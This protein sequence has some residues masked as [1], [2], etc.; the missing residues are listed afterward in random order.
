MHEELALVLVGR[1]VVQD[2]GGQAVLAVV[3]VPGIK[4]LMLAIG[5]GPALCI[6]GVEHLRPIDHLVDHGIIDPALLRQLHAEQARHADRVDHSVSG[7]DGAVVVRCVVAPRPEGVRHR[8]V[9]AGS[10]RNVDGQGFD[11]RKHLGVPGDQVI[12]PQEDQFVSPAPRSRITGGCRVVPQVIQLGRALD[13]GP[14]LVLGLLQV[15]RP[16][17]EQSCPGPREGSAPPGDTFRSSRCCSSS[18]CPPRGSAPTSGS[19]RERWR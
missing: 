5:D 17:R 3:F 13:Q 15:E 18:P 2:D 9:M 12:L 7:V 1:I 10:L 6:R 16:V 4:R 11:G 14:R 8:A 19:C